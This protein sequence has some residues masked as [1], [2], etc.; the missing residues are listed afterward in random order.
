MCDRSS[1]I[2][3]S[4]PILTGGEHSVGHRNTSQVSKKSASAREILEGE[5]WA[6]T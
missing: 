2:V 1:D 3:L 6:A 4:S 5:S